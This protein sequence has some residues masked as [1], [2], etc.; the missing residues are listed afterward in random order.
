MAG[1]TGKEVHQAMKN[2]ESD[3]QSELREFD[4]S[5]AGVKGLVDAGITKIPR[6]FV[7]DNDKPGFNPS[8]GNS[9]F[10]FPIIDVKGIDDPAARPEIVRKVKEACGE[11]GFFQIVNHEMPVSVMNEMIEGVRRFNEQ[12]TEVKKKYYT[13]D[14]T[15][16]FQF[17]SNFNLYTASA[18]AWRDTVTCVM[19]PDAPDPEEFPDNLM[20]SLQ[21]H[22]V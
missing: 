18:A 11:W 19:V 12:D 7:D 4:N 13:R 17:K 6:F 21:R 22:H 1:T 3:R 14:P 2:A 15:R 9:G 5:M 8:N 10:C 20:L 16:R